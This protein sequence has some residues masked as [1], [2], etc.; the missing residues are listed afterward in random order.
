MYFCRAVDINYYSLSTQPAG[1][2]PVWLYI[3]FAASTEEIS[4]PLH[5]IAKDISN[6]QK[7]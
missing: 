2:M 3:S 6:T 5:G 7:Y 1:S 4:S